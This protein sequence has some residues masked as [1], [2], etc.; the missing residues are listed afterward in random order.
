[1]NTAEQDWERFTKI[2]REGGTLF[3]H[4]EDAAVFRASA[5]RVFESIEG[6]DVRESS[7]VQRGK[8]V[9]IAKEVFTIP[10]PVFPARSFR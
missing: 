9:A 6:F 10:T 2:L 3:M 5:T 7:N 8:P 4:P 1:M